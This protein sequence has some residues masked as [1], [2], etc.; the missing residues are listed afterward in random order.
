M[1][2]LISQRVAR[3]SAKYTGGCANVKLP[4]HRSWYMIDAPEIFITLK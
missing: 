2:S 4:H 1:N 3:N